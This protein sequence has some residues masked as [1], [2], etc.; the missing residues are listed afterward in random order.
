MT[1]ETPV[2]WRR[3]TGVFVVN[4]TL[5]AL[6]EPSSWNELR[7]FASGTQGVDSWRPMNQAHAYLGMAAEEPLY[8]WLFFGQKI[9]FIYP[10]TSLLLLDVLP[11]DSLLGAL[12]LFSWLL[13]VLT[14][15]FSV[16]VFDLVLQR[17]R[18]AASADRDRATRAAIAALLALCF[19]PVLKAYS[20]GQMQVWVNGLFAA[21]LYCWLSDRKATAGVL[22]ALMAAVK[23]QYG[24]I[25]LWG[26]LRGERRDVARW[27]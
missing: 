15:G 6:G 11:R 23:P 1:D 25:A 12:N 9:K 26:L 5:T 14:V 17:S 22:V 2:A 24:V 8:Q 10:P 7:L 19:Y 13:V 20:L 16:G 4:A 18:F 3:D 27:R 21:C